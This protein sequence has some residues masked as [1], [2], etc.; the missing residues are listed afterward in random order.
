MAQSCVMLGILFGSLLFGY[1][2]DKYGRRKIVYMSPLCITVVTI[3]GIF[4]PNYNFYLLMRL[5]AG[6]FCGG[7]GMIGFVLITE[8]LGQSKRAFAGMVLPMCFAVGLGIYSLLAYYIRSWKLLTIVT[9]LP[10]L[11]GI[12]MYW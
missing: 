3:L 12:P 2:A 9:S 8:V 5:L 4:S 6:L 10:M 1:L 11:V 7:V